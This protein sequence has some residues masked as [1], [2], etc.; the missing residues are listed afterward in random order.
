MV[1][2][3]LTRLMLATHKIVEA[4]PKMAVFR[5]FAT[6]FSCR[7]CVRSGEVDRALVGQFDSGLAA[8]R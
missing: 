8:L 5:G 6:V 2:M 4:C 1:L 3:H 7:A